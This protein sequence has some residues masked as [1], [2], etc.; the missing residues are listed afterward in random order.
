[1]VAF[2]FTEEN[3]RE[4]FPVIDRVARMCI[5]KG[6][7]EYLD[8]LMSVIQR[9]YIPPYYD[10]KMQHMGLAIECNRSSIARLIV[11]SLKGTGRTLMIASGMYH[12]IQLR[13]REAFHYFYSQVICDDDENQLFMCTDITLDHILSQTGVS[14][15]IT[16]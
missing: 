12:S 2:P 7:V 9:C 5:R 11:D 3:R 1:M 6:A 8:T 10:H 14:W 4:V 13:N 16:L 15:D